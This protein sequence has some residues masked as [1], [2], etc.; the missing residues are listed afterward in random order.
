MDTLPPGKQPG[1]VIAPSSRKNWDLRLGKSTEH[2]TKEVLGT[3]AVQYFLHDSD[4]TYENMSFELSKAWKYLQSG[5]VLVC[6]N[7]YTNSAFSD[8]CAEKKTTP[9]LFPEASK[10]RFG[11]VVKS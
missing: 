10:N 8:F 3:T 5:G 11:I 2:L 1:W 4:H 6:D 9:L 7:I